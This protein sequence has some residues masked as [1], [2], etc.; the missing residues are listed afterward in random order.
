MVAMPTV[1]EN[2]IKPALV[3]RHPALATL[4][5]ERNS[6]KFDEPECVNPYADAERGMKKVGGHVSNYDHMTDTSPRPSETRLKENLQEQKSAN[7][8]EGILR[9]SSVIGLSTNHEGPIKN[10]ATQNG[11]IKST[12]VETINQDGSVKVTYSNG[13]HKHISADGRVVT[14]TYFNGDTKQTFHDGR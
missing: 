10:S 14:M 8:A 5:L 6:V 2:T 12:A 11:P 4:D 7:K 1:S 3:Q 13:T 9:E